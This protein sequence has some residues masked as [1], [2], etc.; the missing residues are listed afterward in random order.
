MTNKE[1]VLNDLRFNDEKL[2]NLLI[3]IRDN[4]GWDEIPSF[5]YITSDGVEFE[6]EYKEALKHEIEWLN[7]KKE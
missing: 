7:S 4:T 2:A 6:D 5:I 3:S 1:K